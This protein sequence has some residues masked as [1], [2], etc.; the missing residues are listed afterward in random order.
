MN[1]L[2]NNGVKLYPPEKWGGNYKLNEKEGKVL[3]LLKLEGGISTIPLCTQTIDRKSASE[4][5]DNMVRRGLVVRVLAATFFN[6][7]LDILF[8]KH[9]KKRISYLQVWE[10]HRVFFIIDLDLLR[11]KYLTEEQNIQQVTNF[12]NNLNK[13]EHEKNLFA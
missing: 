10:K 4:T 7:N 6:Q 8:R 9:I 3:K 11:S 1:D 2:I 5:I 12:I 13:N